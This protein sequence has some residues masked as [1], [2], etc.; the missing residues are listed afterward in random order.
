MFRSSSDQPQGPYTKHEYINHWRIIRYVKMLVYFYML[1]WWK[2]PEDDIKKIETFG[3]L[4]D[5]MWKCMF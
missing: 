5:C 1:V 4:V 3:V 2:L